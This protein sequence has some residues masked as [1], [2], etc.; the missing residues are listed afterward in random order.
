[1]GGLTCLKQGPG[2]T[3]HC[4]WLKEGRT[5]GQDMAAIFIIGGGRR[6]LPA[7]EGIDIRLA[8]WLPGKPAEGHPPL[9]NYPGR[10][11]SDLK[12]R[13]ITSWGGVK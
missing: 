13:T 2:V 8:L 11:S 5:Q 6:R 12:I 10:D 1:M 7:T 9:I 4:V 3:L